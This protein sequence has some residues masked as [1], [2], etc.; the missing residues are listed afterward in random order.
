MTRVSLW[1]HCSKV[2]MKGR[3]QRKS[4]GDMSSG[5]EHQERKMMRN[6]DKSTRD[7]APVSQKKTSHLLNWEWRVLCPGTGSAFRLYYGP[8]FWSSTQTLVFKQ[9]L[10]SP[11]GCW[12]S[13]SRSRS[14]GQSAGQLP[15]PPFLDSRE[16]KPECPGILASRHPFKTGN[17][18]VRCAF[19]SWGHVREWNEAEGRGERLVE[20]L[21]SRLPWDT[22]EEAH[23]FPSSLSFLCE[24]CPGAHSQ[25]TQLV[26]G[27]HRCSLVC[28]LRGS[29]L[30]QQDGLHVGRYPCKELH[31]L[32]LTLFG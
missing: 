25:I 32:L 20:G 21:E 22:S 3:F 17:E 18:N 14:W 7:T 8:V 26:P 11:N 24:G 13:Q 4:P 30:T 1:R 2:G 27:S 6:L 15:L 16:W 31:S 5:A 10:P 19:S 28:L 9:P 29:L 12:G 23:P